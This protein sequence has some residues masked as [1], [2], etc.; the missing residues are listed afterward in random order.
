M[1]NNNLYK[2]ENTLRSIAKRYKSVK[3]SLGLAILFLMMGVGAFSEEIANPQVNVAPT[4]EEIATSKENLKN[5]VGSLQSKID[6]ARAENEKGLA[7]LRL[8]LIQLMEQGNQVVKSPWMSW[9]F[10]ANYMYNKWNGTYKG[11]GDKAEKYIFNGI[12][13]RG[14]WKVRNAMNVAASNGPTGAPITPGNENTSSWKNLNSGSSGGVTIEKDSSISSGTNGNRSWG[15]VDLRNLQEPTNEV[16]LLAHISP[17]EVTKNK[18]DLNVV[19]S[20]PTTISAPVVNPQVNTPVPPPTVE[21]PEKPDLAI[22]GEPTL[23]VNPT[24]NLLTIKKV[25]A[26]TVNPAAVNPVDF[27]LSPSVLSSD[28]A[29]NYTDKDYTPSDWNGQTIDVDTTG[30]NGKYKVGN[31]IST[32]GKVKNLDKF[33]LTVNVKIPDTRAFMVDEGVVDDYPGGVAG[34]EPTTYKPFT[35]SGTINL[36]KSKNVGIDVQGTHTLYGG[37]SGRNDSYNTIEK[38]ANIRVINKGKIIGKAGTNNE[39]QVGFGFNNFDTSSNNT[40]TEMINNGEIEIGAAKS[41]GFQ[42]RPET[43]FSDRRNKESGLVIMSGENTGKI[44]LNGYGSFGFLTVQNKQSGADQIADYDNYKVR[45]T[46]GGQ[47]ASRSKPAE[48]SYMRN[49]GTINVN[50]DDSVGV[51]LLHNIQSVEVGGTINVGATAPTETLANGGSGSDTTKVEGAIGVYSEVETRP[52]RARE[53][54]RGSHGEQLFDGHGKPIVNKSYY[55][56]HAIENVEHTTEPFSY[57]ENGVNKTVNNYTGKMVGTDTVEV[58]GAVNVGQHALNSSGLRVKKSGSITLKGTGVVTVEGKK[59]YGAIVEGEQYNRYDKTK[60]D[61]YATATTDWGKINIDGT[62]NVTGQ[63]SIGYVL[64]SGQGTNSGTIKVTGH[65]DNKAGASYEG[66]LGFYGVKGTFTN[67]GTIEAS[68]KIAHAVVAKTSNMT[69][70]HYGTI[71]V[72]SPNTDKGNIAVYSDGFSKVNFYNNSKVYVGDYS[73]GIHSADKAKF[74]NTFKNLGT[75]NIKIGKESTFAYLDGDATT[76]LKEFFGN[77][78]VNLEEEMGQ[79]SSVVYASNEAKANLDTDYTITKGS[80][81]STIALL[82]SNKATVSV[83]SGKK[84]TT[85]TNVALAAVDGTSTAG[86]GSTAQNNG[87]ILSTRTNGGGIGIYSKDNGSKGINAG[88]ITMQGKN[89][90][91]MYGKNVTTLENQANKVIET[92]KEESVGMYGEVDG[93]GTNKFT[94]KNAGTINIGEK[95]S[96]GIYVKNAS[97]G[98]N[99]EDNL[100]V[101]NNGEINLNSGEELIGIYAPKSTVSKVGKISLAD[102]VTKS[103]A[104]YI[105]GGAK[106]ADTSTAEINLGTSGKNIA[107]Y[108]KNKDTSLGTAA[109][110]GKITGYGVGVYLE[111]KNSTDIAKLDSTSPA[112]NFKQGGATGNGIIGLYLKGST[113]ISGYNKDITVGDTVSGKYA[114]GIYA[115][116]QGT[117]ANKYKINT[118]ITSGKKSVGI[119]ADKD[120]SNNKSYIE[121]K[122]IMNLGEGATGFYVDGEMQLDK[123]TAGAATINLAGGVVAYVTENSKFYGG[124]AVVNLTKSGI[125]VYGKKGSTVNVGNWTFNNNG[126]EAEEIRLEEGQAP[127][128]PT[129]GNKNLKPKM[130]LS[131]VI[132]GE[133]YLESGKTVTS[134]DDGTIKAE[135]NIGLMAQGIKNKIVTGITWKEADYEIENYG[136]IDFSAAKRSTAI[137]SESARAKN[138]GTIK[139]GENSTGIYGIYKD[140]TRKFDGSGPGAKN[141]LEITTTTN[142]KINLGNNST[143]MYLVNAQKLDNLGGEIKSTTGATKNVGIYAL[144]GATSDAAYNKNENY[145]I[146]T[147]NNKANI[148]LGDG[149]VGIFSRGKGIAPAERNTV[150]NTGDITV[151]KNLTDA[152]TVAMY[153]ENTKLDTNSNVTVGE[154]GI[155]F[156][157]KH[158]EITAKGTANFQNKGVLAYLE[159]SKFTSYLGNLNATQNTMMYL[160]N[161]IANLAGNGTKVDMTV[162]DNFT[163]AYIEG[164]STLT[165]VKTVELGKNSSGL[166]LKN[167]NFTSDIEKITSTKE[168]AK[169]LL[170]IES[171]LTNNSKINLS[172]DGSIGIYSNATGKTITNNGELTISG[173]KTLG[174]F[175]KG[176]QTFVNT[177][178]INVADTT[179]TRDD[180]KTIGI[181]T[182]EGTSNIKHNSGIIEVGHKSIGIYSTTN[183]AVE[184]NGGKIH[185][186]DQGIGIYKKDGTLVVKG[187]LDIDAHTATDK[188]SEPAGVYAEDGANITDS[189]SKI[190]VGAKS[191]GFILNNEDTVKE[192]VYNSTNT[193]TVSLGNDSVFLYSSG[194]AKINNGRNISSNADRLIAFYIKGTNKGKGDFTNNATIDFSNTKGSIG[195]Y[196]PNGKAT[197]K[198][199]VLVGRTDDIDPATGKVYTDVSKIVYGIGMAA[200]NGGHIINDGEIR[201][202]GNKS[203][204]MYGKGVGTIVENTANGKIYLDGSRATATDKIQSMTGVY[205]DDGATFINRGNIRTTEAYAGKNGKV[206]DNVSGLVGVA[207]MNGSTLENYGN[208]E[209]D[210]DNSYGVIIR[211]KK[212]ANG[213]VERYAVIKNYGNIRVRGRGTY[214]ISWKD[215]KEADIKALEDQ[216]NSKL[217]SDPNGQELRGAGGTDKD[218]EGVKITV[219]DGKPTFSRGGKPVPDSEVEKIEKIIGGAKSNLGISDVGF[220]IDTL[221]RT[222]PIDIDGAIAPINSQLIVGTEYSELTNKKEWFVKEDVLKPF[223]QQIQGRNFK[224]TSLAGSLTWLATPVLDNNGQIKG[225]AMTKLPYTSFVKKT[226]NAWNFADGL[227]QRYGMNALDSRE[228]KLFNLLNGIGKNEQAILVQAFDEMMGHQYANTQQRINATGNILDKEFSYLK[229]EWHNPTKDSN[230][231]KT[232]GTNGEYKT[233]TAG[234]IDYKYNAYGVAYVH[235]NEDI[236]L[237]K[238]TGWYAG[239]VHN[240]FK[241][242]DIGNSKEQMLQVKVGLLKSVPFDDNN[243][244]NWTISGDIFVGRNRMHRKFLVVDE[245][246]NAKSKYY[247]YGIGVRNEIGKEFRLSEGFTLRPYAALKL[248]Y[249]RV[250]KIKE[251]SGE[252]KLEVKQNDYISMKPEIGTELAYRHYFGTKTLRTS[253]GIAYENELGKLANG[254]NKARVADTTADWFNIRGEKEDRKGNVKVDLN[255]GVDNTRVGVTANVGYDTKGENLRGG[256]GLRVIF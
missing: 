219:K 225:I 247:T 196:A 169:G 100:K 42:L 132:N 184:M 187:E 21:L 37:V 43:Y 13:T 89:A 93:A 207:V 141:K 140:D 223:L 164:N 94:V 128:N 36:E 189:A 134:V 20:A 56:D 158:S 190:T 4:R 156:Y 145:N 73:V 172:G 64:K 142:S 110:L 83:E 224:L 106:I 77:S 99:L 98:S 40:R 152:P 234:I 50:S 233:D 34:V 230:K 139:V 7:G 168:G 63:E 250:S 235:E 159:N 75:L 179:S 60:K 112:L 2:V 79:S 15:L 174:V 9:Q 72:S 183:S 217:T 255:V 69:F 153:A 195:I 51:G 222:K 90:V 213:N 215:V 18:V 210:A 8:E 165:G 31:Y 198:G 119:F 167:A 117:S 52:I 236:K 103:V 218:Y 205:V 48:M 53:Y 80:N 88:T 245:I 11:R 101:E 200:D 46:K 24:I 240:T 130:V 23:T 6:A 135:Q 160:K 173:K 17:K 3:Y 209:I 105:S 33:N 10:G 182:S 67:T 237:G 188:N 47:I 191:Y 185:V 249:G 127:I 122:G 70:N 97:T 107:Y 178:N 133:T 39:N 181:Y 157:G 216:I 115:E 228:K 102:S 104:T 124:K 76:T 123:N 137:Y 126:N 251:K 38:V 25:G 180:E 16:E 54:A 146:L 58:S 212:D 120:S 256:L 138:D 248:E 109:H 170:A 81:A 232:F 29:R 192:N 221:G 85:N 108:V 91:G 116:G 175:L 27:A 231:I 177:A 44:T 118:N 147:M 166:F 208:I 71:K 161:S 92:Q 226:D 243:S 241:F 220:Y 57:Q 242:K 197:N 78:K 96:A 84:L 176:S 87:T 22:P 143:G 253:V 163:G 154:N 148:T 246:F 214:G 113:D 14:N 136:T 62:I 150:T 95:K 1:G 5:S 244:L 28:N 55:D 206:N 203:I 144:N 239:I 26:I 125:G 114:M 149:S 211:G 82:A 59:N 12:Y 86:S 155:A 238:G 65:T 202:Y 41:A 74:N 162:A 186:K 61:E 254:K 19:V 66:S 129:S 199:R 49:S 111:G 35:F 227:E 229:D 201:V 121:Y 194:K 32:W 30:M 193:G 131:H 252:V 68:G 45:A 171:N 151:G 204:G